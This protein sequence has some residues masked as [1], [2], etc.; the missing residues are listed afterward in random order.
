MFTLCFRIMWWTFSLDQIFNHWIQFFISALNKPGR[1]RWSLNTDVDMALGLCHSHYTKL[2]HPH[3]SPH[4]TAVFSLTLRLSF[5]PHRLQTVKHFPPFVSDGLLH[6]ELRGN[7]RYMT[8][9]RQK[10]QCLCVCGK[11]SKGREGWGRVRGGKAVVSGFNFIWLAAINR[12]RGR[13]R[14]IKW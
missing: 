5:S 6:S 13:E 4:I 10:H 11:G 2:I 14:V 9:W 1:Q 12:E 3:Q 8:D 7:R